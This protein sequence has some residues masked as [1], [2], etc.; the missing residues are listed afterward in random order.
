MYRAFQKL[1]SNSALTL[2]RPQRVHILGGGG[3]FRNEAFRGENLILCHFYVFKITLLQTANVT[4]NWNFALAT[5][6]IHVF[7]NILGHNSR[8]I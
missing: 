6:S 4:Q 3:V 2:T 5:S 1:P 8:V 7:F